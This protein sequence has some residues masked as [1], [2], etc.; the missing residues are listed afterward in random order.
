MQEIKNEE[1]NKKV[2]QELMDECTKIK[3]S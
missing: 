1:H 2:M 3:N